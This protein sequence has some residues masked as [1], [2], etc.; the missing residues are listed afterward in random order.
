MCAQR[1]CLRTEQGQVVW[2]PGGH[3]WEGDGRLPRNREDPGVGEQQTLVSPRVRRPLSQF[4]PVVW[5]P[6]A[7][8]EAEE[9]LPAQSCCPG[10]GHDAC[11]SGCQVDILH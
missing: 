11:R 1:R 2:Q 8:R 5:N 9:E 7:G 10:S 3:S 4:P 6:G